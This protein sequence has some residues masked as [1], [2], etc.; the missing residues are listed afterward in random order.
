MLFS[1]SIS[2]IAFEFDAVNLLYNNLENLNQEQLRDFYLII[3]EVITIR[4]RL[5]SVINDEIL[6]DLGPRTAT[7]NGVRLA[8]QFHNFARHLRFRG[9]RLVNLLRDIENRLEIPENERVPSFS[10]EL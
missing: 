2:F 10:F 4:E 1:L 7:E 6:A 9:T 3:Q 8:F 5:I